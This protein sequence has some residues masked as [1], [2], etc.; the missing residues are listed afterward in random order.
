[1]MDSKMK[2]RVTGTKFSFALDRILTAPPFAR[3]STA[4]NW[5]DLI[6]AEMI[7]A[8]VMHKLVGNMEAKK[9]KII[10]ITAVMHK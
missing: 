7:I 10:A 5:T 1:M 8:S 3:S 9:K 4:L 2:N 6:I